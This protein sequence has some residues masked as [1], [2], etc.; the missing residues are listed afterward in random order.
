[1]SKFDH[2]ILILN[3]KTKL[4]HEMEHQP[5]GS[6]GEARRVWDLGEINRI[7]EVNK[8]DSDGGEGRIGISRV[9]DETDVALYRGEVVV[10]N[11][12]IVEDYVSV[13]NNVDE[14]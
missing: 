9:V 2:K 3:D 5:S 14:R 1:M 8:A 7:N 12:R 13:G 10:E 6:S 4:V 11:S